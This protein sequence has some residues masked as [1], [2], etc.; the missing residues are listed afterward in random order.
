MTWRIKR[1]LRQCTPFL[2]K[3]SLRHLWQRIRWGF[4]DSD[5]WSLDTTIAKFVLPRLKRFRDV[6][7]GYP[8]CDGMA[9]E[10]DWN[11]AMDEMIFAMQVVIDDGNCDLRTHEDW[12]R[13]K[14]GLKLF[15]KWFR[16]LW[17]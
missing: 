10:E 11:V 6:S 16:Q 15:G 4:D 7:G 5:L 14:R 1:A 12:A 8:G 3:R 9:T 2:I 13:C 17:W